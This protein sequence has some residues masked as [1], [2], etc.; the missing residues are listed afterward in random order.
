M[1]TGC[2]VVSLS[3]ETKPRQKRRYDPLWLESIFQFA[4]AIHQ[5]D[6]NRRLLANP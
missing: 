2:R 5:F 4:D 3:P 6:S 1:A